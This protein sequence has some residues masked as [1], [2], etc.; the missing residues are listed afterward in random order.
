MFRADWSEKPSA[1]VWRDIV[2]HVA[3]SRA[4]QLA[5]TVPALALPPVQPGATT[6]SALRRPL[7]GVRLGGAGGAASPPSPPQARSEPALTR[8][9]RHRR[10]RLRMGTG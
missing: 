9:A 6:P 4:A 3:K 8:V 1:K 5:Y 7:V 10:K 2:R